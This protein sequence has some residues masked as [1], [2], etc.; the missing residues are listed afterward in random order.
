MLIIRKSKISGCY[1]ISHPIFRDHRGFLTKIF[2]DDLNK[3]LNN[4]KIKQ[5]N[6]SLTKKKHSIRGLHYQNPCPEYK[7][8][9]CLDGKIFDVVVDLRKNSKT[10]LRHERFIID[11]NSS[12]ILVIP[13]NCAHGY[14]TLK[15][16]C[17]I[18]Y[19]HTNNY[20]PQHSKGLYYKDPI[21]GIKWPHK[22][23]NLS[24][25]DKS[26]KLIKD[27]KFKGL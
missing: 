14:Q 11:S 20:Y 27:I 13:E 16:S 6:Y 12:S 8:V 5:I 2:S 26:L 22:A 9:K 7:I 18:L 23:S 25:N 15:P 19:F 17:K 21:L 3:Y 4:K 1:L 24:D 10:F